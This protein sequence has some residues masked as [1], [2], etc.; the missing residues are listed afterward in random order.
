[1]IL[2]YIRPGLAQQNINMT[3][4]SGTARWE[5]TVSGISSGQT[6]QYQ[7]TYQKNGLQYDTAWFSWVKP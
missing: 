3:Y 1:V 7:F 2:H 4:N 5:Y 6:L